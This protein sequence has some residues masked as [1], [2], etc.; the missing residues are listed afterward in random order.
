MGEYSK[1]LNREEAGKFLARKLMEYKND[2]SVIILALPRGGVPVGYVIAY[3]LHKPLDIY[4]VKKIGV[5]GQEELAMGAVSTSGEVSIDSGIVE[6]L[7]ISD[8]DL[9][10]LIDFK[11]A[12]IKD[13]EQL[14]RGSKPPLDLSNRTVILVDD[15]LATGA[16]MLTAIRSIKKLQPAKIIAAIPV[17]SRDAIEMVQG[18]VDE[19]ICL[20]IPDFFYSVSVWYSDFRQTTDGEVINLLNRSSDLFGDNY[21]KSVA[22]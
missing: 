4:L 13:R 14:L 1:F 18:E 22:I 8:A 6:R 15:G 17:A 2:D 12:E 11:K 16:T 10:E 7:H 5:P 21:K 9:N 3:A 19:A 20:L